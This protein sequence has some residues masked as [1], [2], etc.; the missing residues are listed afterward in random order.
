[1]T[2]RRLESWHYWE[3]EEYGVQQ[4]LRRYRYGF[5][6][7]SCQKSVGNSTNVSSTFSPFPPRSLRPS[8]GLWSRKGCQR[9]LRYIWCRRKCGHSPICPAAY[10]DLDATGQ[11]ICR[12]YVKQM[13]LQLTSTPWYRGIFFS[14]TGGVKSVARSRHAW[15]RNRSNDSDPTCAT[16]WALVIDR[17]V[18]PYIPAFHLTLLLS[19]AVILVVYDYAL[20]WSKRTKG[21][22]SYKVEV[23]FV[24]FI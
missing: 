16:F 9:S 24:C 4:G 19:T 11:V 10:E 13:A 21:P 1:M 5:S 22:F 7:E 15:R 14:L 20:V 12:Y 17:T 18:S 3:N 2:C 8:L 23:N 6:Y